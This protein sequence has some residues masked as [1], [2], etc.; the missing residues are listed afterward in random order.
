MHIPNVHEMILDEL[1]ELKMMILELK[2][3]QLDKNGVD[4]EKYLTV[5]K[6][7]EFLNCSIDFIYKLK[8]RIPHSKINAKLY[9]KIGDL[10]NYLDSGRIVPR[11][12]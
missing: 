6:T 8:N 10:N 9:F 3:A 12:M 7:A 5:E 11:K 2:D 4:T 1:A